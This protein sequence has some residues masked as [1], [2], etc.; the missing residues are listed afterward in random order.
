MCCCVSHVWAGTAVSC[1]KSMFSPVVRLE[2]DE[3]MEE[4]VALF[5]WKGRGRVGVRLCV[6]VGGQGEESVT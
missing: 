6:C 2:D 4:F 1:I 5:V 3:L